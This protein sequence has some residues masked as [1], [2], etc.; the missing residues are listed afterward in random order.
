MYYPNFSNLNCFIR[1]TRIP[2]KIYINSE[3]HIRLYSPHNW[4]K[5]PGYEERYG[6]N[7]GF[8]QISAIAGGTLS[9]DQVVGQEASHQLE[10][11]GTRPVISS[12]KIQEQPARLILPSSD[13][14]PEMQKQAALIVK[15]PSPI[16]IAGI[17]YEYFILWADVSH[18]HLIAQS[19]Q[20]L[21]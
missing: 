11:Y 12:L 20:F 1:G 9:L 15:Y 2:T 3:Y 5:I 8:F 14:P 7:G 10:P 4:V 21:K 6:G 17:N 19:L 16:Q 13:Q 18:I